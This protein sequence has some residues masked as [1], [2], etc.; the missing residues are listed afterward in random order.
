[1]SNTDNY[2][3]NTF[4]L[5]QAYSYT[6]LL[7]VE[8]NS[9]S[10]AVVN[11][12]R[13]LVSAQDC[14]L[15]ELAQPRHL[16]DLLSA[17]YRKVVIGMP[18]AAL[19]LVPESLFSEDK[20]S[21]FARYLDVKDDEKVFAQKLDEQ[22]AVIYKTNSRLI[23]IVAKFGLQNTVYTA[24]GWIKA[25]S[26]QNPSG[27]SLYL[28]VSNDRVQFVYFALDSIRFYNTF[29]FKT[30]DELVYFTSF[31][32]E[33]LNLRPQNI[34]LVVSGDIT[35]GDKNLVRLGNFYPKIELNSAK[36]LDIPPLIPSHKIL[37][38]TALSLCAL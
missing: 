34:T 31:V 37:S 21:A 30:E 14:D 3:D 38:L 36:V 7:Q 16:H 33:E 1:M 27:N 29:E 6:L 28:D 18:S 5:H 32:A 35:A 26:Q 2:T 17:T 4:N 20:V 11:N 8:A 25:I 13:L 10:Y 9:F 24:K 19:T 15:Q 12:N 23:D 22:N